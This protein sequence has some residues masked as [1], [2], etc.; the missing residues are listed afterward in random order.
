MHPADQIRV[1][2][3]LGSSVYDLQNCKIGSVK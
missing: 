1:R 2:K 3:M